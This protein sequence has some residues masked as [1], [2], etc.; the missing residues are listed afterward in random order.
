MCGRK[1][2]TNYMPE[3]TVN[4]W[5]PRFSVAEIPSEIKNE[6]SSFALRVV[7]WYLPCGIDRLTASNRPE[8][9]NQWLTIDG[10]SENM[11]EAFIIL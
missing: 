6:S 9:V 5:K 7:N 11:S 3:R 1:F 2:K 4:G 8:K 10:L